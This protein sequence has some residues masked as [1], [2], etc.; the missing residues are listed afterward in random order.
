ML[1]NAYLLWY[2]FSLDAALV[3]GDKHEKTRDLLEFYF[4]DSNLL[5]DRYETWNWH[6]CV[7]IHLFPGMYVKERQRASVI[8]S[9]RVISTSSL[10]FVL[11]LK[12]SSERMLC[13]YASWDARAYSSVE[14]TEVAI[15]A[16]VASAPHDVC[17]RT[18]MLTFFDVC[19]RMLTYLDVCWRMLTYAD[20]CRS[21][22]S[23]T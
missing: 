21:G 5:K 22:H 16:P 8:I 11:C 1:R 23:V 12:K 4:G 14:V 10:Y 15:G 13:V 3:V 6:V 7:Y 20:V 19:C 2:H 9:L 17:W 18:R